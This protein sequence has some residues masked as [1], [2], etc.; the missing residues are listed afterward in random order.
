MI[1]EQ[2]EKLCINVK[3]VLSVLGD[4][5]TNENYDQA[6]IRFLIDYLTLLHTTYAIHTLYHSLPLAS[7]MN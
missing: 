3:T 1:K 2:E 5:S 4:L 7:R 6:N